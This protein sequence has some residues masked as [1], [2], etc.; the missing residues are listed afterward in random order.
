MQLQWR[1]FSIRLAATNAGLL[2]LAAHDAKPDLLLELSEASPLVL[3]QGLLRG[4][5]PLVRVAGDVQFAAEI[6]W[7]VDHVRW[8]MEE[9]L[10]RVVGDAAAYTLAQ[11]GQAVVKALRQFIDA[12]V[13]SS[14]DK[15]S[16]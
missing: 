2:D 1:A 8:E 16:T 3:A 9:D 6:N 11:A 15:A 4:E 7:L 13:T 5:R 12:S 10:A 14:P